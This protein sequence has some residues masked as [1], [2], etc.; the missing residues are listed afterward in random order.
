MPLDEIF[1]RLMRDGFGGFNGRSFDD[2]ADMD[3]YQA[4]H[5]LFRN[6]DEEESE[7]EERP[8]G[9]PVGFQ[10]LYVMRWKAQGLSMAEIKAK[11]EADFPKQHY[12]NEDV[13]KVLS[14]MEWTGG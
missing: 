1:A 14:E 5:I 6:L 7:E 13:R 8:S 9:E 11:W 12:E 3:R 2:I 4:M 10:Q